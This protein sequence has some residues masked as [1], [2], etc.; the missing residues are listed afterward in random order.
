MRAT[1]RTVISGREG[2][3]E[4]QKALSCRSEGHSRNEG[5]SR[6]TPPREPGPL[7]DPLPAITRIDGHNPQGV[8]GPM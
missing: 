3:E 6:A 7:R 1:H 2:A 5:E 4:P 8:E